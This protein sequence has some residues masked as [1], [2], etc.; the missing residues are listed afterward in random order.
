MKQ[1]INLIETIIE[2]GVEKTDRTGV[3]TISIFGHQEKFKLNE[4]FPLLTLKETHFP[5]IVHE[6]LWFLNAVPERYKKFGNTNIKYL[7]DNKV[8]IWN[9]WALKPYLL[10]N[11]KSHIKVDPKDPEWRTEMKAFVVKIKEDDEFALK[12]GDLGTVYG[13]QWRKWPTFHRDQA[14]PFLFEE[15]EIDQI[16]N[17]INQLKQRPD[18]RGI[19]VSAWN[20]AELDKMALRPCHTF[21]QLNTQ[22]L[23]KSEL[24]D[25]AYERY[26]KH[27]QVLPKEEKEEEITQAKE[28]FY[29]WWHQ[30]YHPKF[31]QGFRT[32]PVFEGMPALKLHLQLYQR[33]ADV[34]LGVP[35]NIASYALL[36]QMIAQVVNMVPGTFIHTFGDAHLYKNHSEQVEKLLER[37]GCGCDGTPRSYGP[38]LPTIELNPTIKKI[39]DFRFED[40]KLVNYNPLEKISAPVAI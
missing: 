35:F 11:N 18:D 24:A 36:L 12:W 29:S 15:R 14:P 7:V 2:E 5:S 33:S 31:G 16:D 3:G 4:G 40:I 25:L 37:V 32:I 17:V 19:M 28:N 13:K 27:L 20:I 9:E 23:Q 10:A 38:D 1:Y 6:L 34:F 21:W 8:N 22:P 30:D 26:L 39:D